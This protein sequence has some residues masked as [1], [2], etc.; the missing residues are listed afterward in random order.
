MRC[1]SC[2][3]FTALEMGEEPEVNIDVEYD[4]EGKQAL[5][6]GTVRI[7]RNCAECGDEMK[8]AEFDV[9]MQIDVD[10]WNLT[11]ETGKDVNVEAENV[12][13]I[14]ETGKGSR[15]KTSY[16][17]SM[18][19]VVKLKDKEIAREKWRDTIA[20]SSMTELV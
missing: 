20:A 19:V 10:G 11:E 3:K 15:P 6:S 7:V 8:E 2:E 1:P 13:A 4:T 12:E 5:V 9:E 18:D 17:A 14:E 16:G